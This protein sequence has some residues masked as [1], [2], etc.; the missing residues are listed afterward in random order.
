[1]QAT[2]ATHTWLSPTLMDPT[3]INSSISVG[4][5]VKLAWESHLGTRQSFLSLIYHRMLIS[6]PPRWLF[7]P[8]PPFARRWKPRCAC[9]CQTVLS[10]DA[11]WPAVSPSAWLRVRANVCHKGAK[12][13]LWCGERLSA[14]ES[15]C[16]LKT[17]RHLFTRVHPGLQLH[18]ASFWTSHTGH[19]MS[20]CPVSLHLRTVHHANRSLSPSPLIILSILGAAFCFGR[21]PSDPWLPRNSLI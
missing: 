6:Y 14:P 5:G 7:T 10:P 1:M 4:R 3:I 16:T 11:V 17:A 18:K 19:K 20:R 13:R 8:Y 9:R 12:C 15:S 2:R 21:W